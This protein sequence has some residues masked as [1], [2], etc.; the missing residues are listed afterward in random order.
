MS[1]NLCLAGMMGVGKST[2]ARALG[3][4]LERRVADTDDEIRGWTGR[5]I[6]ELFAEHGEQ[7]FRELERRVVEEL[8]TFDDLVISLGGGAVLRDDNVASLLLTGVVIHLD[9]PVEV[10]GERLL[11]G[12][13]D[14]RPLLGGPGGTE[15]ELLERLRDTYAERRP[16]Y[17]EVADVTVDASGS[18]ESV[19]EAILSWACEQDGVLTPSEHE[20]VLS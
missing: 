16:R 13:S 19:V 3:E 5:S 11:V 18:P 20:A 15:S 17:L 10:L 2:V 7:G 1:R 14:D 8:A 12:E 4:W 6:P 9:A